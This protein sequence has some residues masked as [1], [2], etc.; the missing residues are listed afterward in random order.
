MSALVRRGHVTR[1]QAL[2]GALGVLAVFGMLLLA[3]AALRRPE[4]PSGA[5]DVL[6]RLGPRESVECRQPAPREGLPRT[7]SVADRSVID[8]DSNSLYECPQFYDGHRV[9]FR[10]EVVGGLLRRDTTVWTQLN[11][12][13]H[14]GLAGPPAHH[15][16]R[17][18]NAGVGVLLSAGMAA[19]VT[20]VGG[21]QTRGDVLEV[22]G[23]F[24]RVDPTGEVA[25]IR[26][27]GARLTA[28]G[29]AV[30]DPPLPDRRVAAVAAIVLAGTAV[31]A[32][33]VVARRR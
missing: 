31:I 10:G 2:A 24:N 28:S 5:T 33:R 7:Q 15:D 29:T 23:T 21:P 19:K 18:G 27:D 14:A 4:L 6:Y 25:V 13:A 17:G 8:V 11:D 22:V 20:F 1:A 16:L 26:A 32:E 30:V 12:D 3:G 9:R